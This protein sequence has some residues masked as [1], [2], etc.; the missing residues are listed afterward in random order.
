[1][2]AQL[3]GQGNQATVFV[4]LVSLMGASLSISFA[5]AMAIHYLDNA[6]VS[7][8]QIVVTTL[9]ILT[10]FTAVLVWPG[11]HASESVDLTKQHPA[12]RDS[13][14]TIPSPLITRT[15]VKPAASI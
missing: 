7:K 2:F 4:A 3:F 11:N 6:I 5:M 8:R 1:M 12:Y 9:L 10:G 15:P 13:A 14:S